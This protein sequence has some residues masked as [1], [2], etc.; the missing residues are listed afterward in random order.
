MSENGEISEN[1]YVDIDG[2]G[3]VLSHPIKRDWG[4]GGDYMAPMN[5]TYG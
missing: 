3:L 5:I 4:V 1:L 2:D